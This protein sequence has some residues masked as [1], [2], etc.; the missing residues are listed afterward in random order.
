MGSIALRLTAFTL[1]MMM[2]ALM[3]SAVVNGSHGHRRLQAVNYQTTPLIA[4]A[5]PG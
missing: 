5:S 3:F 1:L 4:P 2:F